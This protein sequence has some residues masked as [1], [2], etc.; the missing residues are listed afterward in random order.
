MFHSLLTCTVF[1]EKSDVHPY[2]CSSVLNMSVWPLPLLSLAAF[3]IFNFITGFNQCYYDVPW[4][5][6]L[7]VSCSWRLQSLDLGVT[8]FFT[9]RK[10]LAIFSSIFLFDMQWQLNDTLFITF[11]SLFSISD[12]FYCCAFQFMNLLLQ[13][14]IAINPIQCIF[15]LRHYCFHL[16]KFDLGSLKYQLNFLDI[17]NAIILPVLM[18]FSAVILTCVSS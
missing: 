12:S 5:S 13:C 11:F 15:Y 16:Q 6:F 7:H 10:I 4:C 18:C 3:W 2:L 8:V 1:N 14:L 17:C 9:S